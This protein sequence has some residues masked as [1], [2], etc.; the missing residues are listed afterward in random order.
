MGC[1]CGRPAGAGRR[2]HRKVLGWLVTGPDGQ[3]YG[4]F[5]TQMEARQTLTAIGGGKLAAVEG[6]NM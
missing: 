5:L 2:T 6:D 1:G 4:P 3:E